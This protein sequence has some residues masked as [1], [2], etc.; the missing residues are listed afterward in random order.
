MLLSV[1]LQAAA[2]TAVSADDATDMGAVAVVVI[3]NPAPPYHI[4]KG[5]DPAFVIFVG[6]AAGIQHGHADAAPGRAGR[7]GSGTGKMCRGSLAHG[8]PRKLF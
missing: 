6:K 8:K 1:L 3:G 4:E 5:R 2:G 7:A